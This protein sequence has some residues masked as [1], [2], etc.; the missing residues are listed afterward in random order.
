MFCCVEPELAGVALVAPPVPVV[1]SGA[2]EV[3]WPWAEAGGFSPTYTVVVALRIPPSPLQESVKLVVVESAGVVVLPCAPPSARIVPPCFTS[4]VTAR[5]AV[6]VIF[7]VLP[8]GIE[9][10]LATN[11]SAGRRTSGAGVF[12]CTGAVGTG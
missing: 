6:Q 1:M 11:A 3:V 4:H 9:L 7:A 8:T 2:G 5:S 10:G 12:G